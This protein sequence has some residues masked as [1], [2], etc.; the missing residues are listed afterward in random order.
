M[1]ARLGRVEVRWKA[2]LDNAGEDAEEELL[3]SV[4]GGNESVI[5]DRERGTFSSRIQMVRWVFHGSGS[6][7]GDFVGG[8]GLGS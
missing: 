6:K 4:D 1:P 3:R 7:C 8:A 5:A 2:G